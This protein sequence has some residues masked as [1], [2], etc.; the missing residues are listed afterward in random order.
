[1]TSQMSSNL[2]KKIEI[3]VSKTII[4]YDEYDNIISQKVY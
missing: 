4:E 2:C 3:Y 1:M